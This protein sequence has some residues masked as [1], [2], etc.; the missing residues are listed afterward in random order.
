MSNNEESAYQDSIDGCEDSAFD[1]FFLRHEP[2]A[3]IDSLEEPDDP[4][5]L[6]RI[7]DRF[8]TDL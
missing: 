1:S 3:V 6:V 7:S 4:R 8:S 5:S 2:S